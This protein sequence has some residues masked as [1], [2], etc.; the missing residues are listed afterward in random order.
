MVRWLPHGSSWALC[1]LFLVATLLVVVV[2]RQWIVVD[3]VPF[4]PQHDI[5]KASSSAA[6]SPKFENVVIFT[7]TPPL[8][9]H[10][11]MVS[12]RALVG[13]SIPSPLLSLDSSFIAA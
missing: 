4:R 5:D 11:I 1:R 7:I 12:L 13:V 10:Q 6:L 2:V 8:N 9:H 3:R